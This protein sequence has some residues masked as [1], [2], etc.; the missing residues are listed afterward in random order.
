MEAA[1]REAAA[2][3]AATEKAAAAA[4]KPA[5]AAVKPAAA[6]R[7]HPRRGGVG[8]TDDRDRQ[9]RRGQDTED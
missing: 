9:S 7:A 2:A 4:V 3:K 5:A 8:R 6:A 1:T